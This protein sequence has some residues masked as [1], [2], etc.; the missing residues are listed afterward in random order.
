MTLNLDQLPAFPAV[1]VEIDLGE[2]RAQRSACPTL[3]PAQLQKRKGEKEERRQKV[4]FFFNVSLF[5]IIIHRGAETSRSVVLDWNTCGTFLLICWKCK[6]TFIYLFLL[7]VNER[8]WRVSPFFTQIWYLLVKDACRF[9]ETNVLGKVGG[10]RVQLQV[11]VCVAK[12]QATLIKKEYVCLLSTVFPWW[13]WGGTILFIL[14][15]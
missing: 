9:N 10:G 13:K 15:K 2:W 6:Y 12:N 3:S 5:Y 1:R 7:H 14:F 8:Q 11:C 4:F